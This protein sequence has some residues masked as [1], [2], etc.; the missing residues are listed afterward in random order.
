MP[1][2]PAVPSVVKVTTPY[3]LEGDPTALCRFFVHYSGTAPTAA[4]LATFA[5]AVSTAWN[6]NLAAFHNLN[7]TEGPVNCEDLTSATGAVG[8]G[9]AT[10]PGTRVGAPIAA[11]SATMVQFGIARRYRGGKPKMFLPAGVAGDLTNSATWGA[12]YLANITAAFNAFI[13]A[14]LAA[15]WAGAGTLTHVNVSYFQGFTVVVNPITHRA[16]NV[17][18]LR[19][20]PVVDT[21]V[22]Y[23]VEQG[24]ASQRR[25]NNV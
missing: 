8:F 14:V 23:S 20:A 1:A 6:G 5:D 12:V 13:A 24:V 3:A 16:R 2:L 25:R 11:G 15:G 19:G 10:H 17:P 22:G 7:V 4:E 21:V 18:T 9:A